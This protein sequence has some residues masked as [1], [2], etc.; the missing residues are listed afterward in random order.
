GA[1]YGAIG[2]FIA[3]TLWDVI[4]RR[5]SQDRR[6]V[7]LRRIFERA[8]GTLIKIGQ[9]MSI[10]L[11]VLPVRYCEELALM[12]DSVPPFPSEDAIAVIERC[13]GKKLEEIFSAFDPQP[14]GSAS[15]ACVYQAVLRDGGEKVAVKVRRPGIWKLFEADFRVLD[16]LTTMAEKLT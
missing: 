13:T 12:L 9:Q 7:R 4:R 2:A 5:D 10:R 16:V 8:G 3:G 15:I 1:W 14:I 6:A 11:D